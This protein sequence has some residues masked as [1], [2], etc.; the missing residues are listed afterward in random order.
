MHITITGHSVGSGG[1]VYQGQNGA[2]W[3]QTGDGGQ[4]QPPIECQERWLV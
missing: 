1:G 4:R 3:H 2:Q